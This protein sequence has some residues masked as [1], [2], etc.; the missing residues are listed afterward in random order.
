MKQDTLTSSLAEFL[1]AAINSLFNP[2][3]A[4]SQPL[5][6]SAS[7]RPIRCAADR[8]TASCQ[9]VELSDQTI[10]ETACAYAIAVS[11]ALH[12]GDLGGAEHITQTFIGYVRAT[13]RPD[14]AYRIWERVHEI[15]NELDDERQE[16]VEMER[17]HAVISSARAAD[18]TGYWRIKER[19][20]LAKGLCAKEVAAIR[21]QAEAI[22]RTLSP[23]TKQDIAV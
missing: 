10:E 17:R 13:Y 8:S 6:C 4:K 20:L 16:W 23:A 5:Q 11:D 22:L 1:D 18:L 19:E 3:A 21:V 9:S 12:S 7:S 15:R 2:A 14:I